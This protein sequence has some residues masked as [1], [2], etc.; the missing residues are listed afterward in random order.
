MSGHKA[1]VGVI[2]KFLFRFRSTV[3]R[4]ASNASKTVYQRNGP[5]R[6]YERDV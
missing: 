4:F 1:T 6:L 5:L 2:K 3:Y